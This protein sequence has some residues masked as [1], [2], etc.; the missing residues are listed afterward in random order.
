[1]LEPFSS[2]RLLLE[3]AREHLDQFNHLE[4]IFV[5][6]NPYTHF[7]Q[8]DP[9]T[10]EHV[11]KVKATEPTKKLSVI[12]F[13]IINCI[14]SALDHAVFDS[15][16]VIGGKPHPK[17]TK[18]PFGKTADD[19]ARDL[20][21]YKD[22][23]V[24]EA[25]RPYLLRFEPYEGGKEALWELNEL[26][27]G[28]IHRILQSFPIAQS[29]VGFGNGWIGNVTLSTCNEWDNENRELTYMRFAAGA[30]YDVEIDVSVRVILGDTSLLGAEPAAEIF[31]KFIEVGERIR[32]GIK[33]ETK[34]L[35]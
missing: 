14:R 2:S 7:S 24:P 20:S 31:A 6:K 4:G 30:D 21:R 10:G 1:M 19:A 5:A 12:A 16:R 28:K 11:F 25:I 8:I 34:R 23:E 3:R 18:F 35:S 26:R 13:D 22:G 15:A 29:G 33:A 17:Y 9:D 27:N 32:L